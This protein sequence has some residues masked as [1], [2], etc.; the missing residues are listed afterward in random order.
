MKHGP[1]L[2]LVSCLKKDSGRIGKVGLWPWDRVLLEADAFGYPR[3]L[4]MD[5]LLCIGFVSR[6]M[7]GPSN[8]LIRASCR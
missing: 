3:S 2:M 6:L 7:L 1:G 4:Y 8:R 5:R